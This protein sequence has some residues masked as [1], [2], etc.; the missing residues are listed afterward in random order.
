MLSEE[1]V[2]TFVRDGFVALRGVVPAEL[3]EQCQDALWK[4]VQAVAGCKREDPATWDRP[5]VRLDQLASEPFRAAAGQPALHEAFDQLVGQGRW[6]PLR[7]LGTWPVRFPSEEEP[8]DDGWHLEASFAGQAGENRVNLRSR[9]RALLLLFLFSEIGPDDAPTRVRTGSHLD[10]PPLLADAGEEGR[11]WFE[12]CGE[13]VPA[14]AD[15]PVAL[16]TGSPGDV[17]LCHPFLVHAAQ[18]HRGTVPRFLAQ[19]PL[20]PTGELD[21][22]GAAPAPVERAVLAGLAT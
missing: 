22:S 13:A 5:V 6:Q 3:A 14:S 20:Q 19:P 18:P 2:E 21:L 4:A 7:A 17:L 16:A 15:R 9:G 12:L 10:V 1:Q 11:E 8:G